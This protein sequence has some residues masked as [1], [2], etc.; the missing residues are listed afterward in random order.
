[1]EQTSHPF[2][3]FFLFREMKDKK[4][5]DESMSFSPSHPTTTQTLVCANHEVFDA[6]KQKVVSPRPF[7]INAE[8]NSRR[9]RRRWETSSVCCCVML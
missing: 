3:L 4:W 5:D 2:F 8:N 9:R 6:K 1:M 7:Q